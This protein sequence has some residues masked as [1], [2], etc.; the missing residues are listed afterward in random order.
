MH[1]WALRDKT[2]YNF[3]RCANWSY[4]ALIS[5]IWNIISYHIYVYLLYA[6][7]IMYLLES[8][9]TTPTIRE[10]T[11]AAPKTT[12]M[13]PSCWG[14]SPSL[15]IRDAWIFKFHTCYLVAWSSQLFVSPHHLFSSSCNLEKK[16]KRMLLLVNY[17]PPSPSPSISLYYISL[18]SG[19]W[20]IYDIDDQQRNLNI[21]NHP[22]CTL[23]KNDRPGD[24]GTLRSV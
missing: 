20:N 11:A 22:I 3:D 12:K 14:P 19:L 7:H 8:I 18:F 1:R 17:W 21:N 2:K 24:D 6:L 23:C 4:Y 9:W 13:P 5:F 16:N 15:T 10:S